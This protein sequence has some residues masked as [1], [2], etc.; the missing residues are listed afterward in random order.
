MIDLVICGMRGRMGQLLVQRATGSTDVRIAAGI[1]RAR[2]AADATGRGGP[3]VISLDDAA[4]AVRSADVVVDFSNAA[5]TRALVERVGDALAGRALVVG[6]T[7]LDPTAME[8]LDRLSQQ[9]AVLVA[10]NF[11]IG[12]NLLIAFTRR[13]AAVLDRDDYDI[14]IIEHHHN[15]KA[16]SP[17]GTALALGAAAADGRGQ[18]L[19]E[20]RRDGR[21]GDDA[22]RVPGEIG[23]HAVR[24]GGVVGEHEV[25][26][27]GG[28]ERIRL[29]HDALDRAL[30][31]DGALAAVRWIAGRPSGRY[32]MTE[33]LGLQAGPQRD[34]G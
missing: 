2:A 15:R 31:A 7:G 27:M 12:V 5:F 29:G 19:A 28:R 23:F 14:E 24:G 1:G 18:P 4:A 10:P 22:G 11:S 20:L 34:R 16:D 32:T 9:A 3:D 8:L 21:S 17:S 26:F 6:T 33:V 25:L 30:F 13:A